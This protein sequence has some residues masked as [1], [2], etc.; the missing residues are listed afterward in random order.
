MKKII[1]AI[2]IIILVFC[3]NSL[4]VGAYPDDP[5]I[6]GPPND[7]PL[8]HDMEGFDIGTRARL[9]YAI[10][11]GDFIAV[12]ANGT[13]WAIDY[14]SLV[15]A[16]ANH[17]PVEMLAA[18]IRAQ[19][20]TIECVDVG[21]TYIINWNQSIDY[22][23]Y[24]V[25]DLIRRSYDGGY[26]QA[27]QDN[28]QALYNKAYEEGR[29]WGFE[30]GL[31]HGISITHPKSY[32]NGYNDGYDEGYFVGY[33]EGI[34]DA[35]V[36]GL[37]ELHQVNNHLYD[38]IDLDRMLLIQRVSQKV[39]NGSE[40][41]VWDVSSI[42]LS[43]YLVRFYY[44]S[45]LTD[46]VVQTNDT[47]TASSNYFTQTT[48]TQEEGF[49]ISSSKY[50]NVTI[51]K[52]RMIGWNDNLTKPQKIELFRNWLSSNNLIIDY[53]IDEKITPITQL[54]LEL[55]PIWQKAYRDGMREG[56]AKGLA[57]GQKQGYAQGYEKA[58][59]VAWMRALFNGFTAFFA[60]KLFGNITIGLIVGVPLFIS[61]ALWVFKLLKGGS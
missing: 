51:S 54:D 41:N 33:D 47:Q 34:Q 22:I 43:P 35:Q 12:E 9:V 58:L 19:Y 45:L 49:Y 32:R 53:K 31:Q 16:D 6:I 39:F 18:L 5:A 37:I 3:L 2:I 25:D 26:N 10:D 27:M 29:A 30:Q 42:T 21:P 14:Y 57:T 60:I 40:A 61:L 36:Q 50:L 55:Q 38:E 20:Y 1:S 23:D 59:D 11:P 7:L 15:D 44:S 52:S 48:S 24:A 46:S 28:Y 4:G 13:Y 17:Y 56:V 8:L